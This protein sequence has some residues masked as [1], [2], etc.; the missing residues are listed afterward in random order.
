MHELS[1]C[2]GSQT[3]CATTHRAARCRVWP[4]QVGLRHLDFDM[5]AFLGH[6]ADVNRQ[7]TV[8]QVSAR[9]GDC[10]DAWCDWLV[11]IPSPVSVATAGL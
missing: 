3:P 6:L 10:L 9:T 8:T 2:R 5:A 1:L 11:A 4:L 7:A